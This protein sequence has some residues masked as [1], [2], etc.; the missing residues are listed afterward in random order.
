MEPFYY[1]TI[2]HIRLAD[3]PNFTTDQPNV[4]TANILYL[5]QKLICNGAKLSI[6]LDGAYYQNHRILFFVSTLGF[7]LLSIIRYRDTFIIPTPDPSDDN[8]NENDILPNSLLTTKTIQNI[9]PYYL[10]S[11]NNDYIY[12]LIKRASTF[13]P[14]FRSFFFNHLNICCPLL[15]KI[16]FINYINSIKNVRLRT[17]YDE[18]LEKRTFLTLK[19]RCRLIIKESI[20][21]Y[22]LDI[23]NLIQLPLTLQYYLSFDLLNPNF[24]QIILDKLNQVNGR[25]KPLFFDELQFHEHPAE[26]INGQTDWEDQ[27]PEDMDFENDD[28]NDAEQEYDDEDAE[29]F[30]EEGLYSDNDEDEW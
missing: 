16:E 29:L 10:D 8:D 17:L 6:P 14:I 20:N 12:Y 7:Y 30:D 18:I 11:I 27:I 23:K 1:E 26:Q 13:T 4:R 9:N 24:V 19:Q 2:D 21:K 22:P 3:V 15:H 5:F 25:I 28:D